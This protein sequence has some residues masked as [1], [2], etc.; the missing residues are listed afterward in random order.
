MMNCN[1]ARA[2]LALDPGAGSDDDRLNEHIAACPA[3]AAYQR[4]NRAIDMA[5][6]DELRWEVPAALTAQLVAIALQGPHF[7]LASRPR[8][9]YVV[10]VYTLTLMVM[11]VSLAVAWN[12][13]VSL[14]AQIGLGDAL[15]RALAAPGQW[16]A[17]LTRSLPESRYV[18]DFA[19]RVR[20][21]LLWLLL[22]AVLWAILDR[23]PQSSLART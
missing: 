17:D 15:A 1:D 13:G 11:A 14:T 19:L 4:R 23:P 16:L 8:R 18:I 5:L 2:L 9:W 3:C 6:R 12:I 7:S 22:V 10:V 20:D 21:Q